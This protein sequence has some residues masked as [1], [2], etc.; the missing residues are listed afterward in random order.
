[1]QKIKLL[2]VLGTFIFIQQFLH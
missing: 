2:Q 1:V